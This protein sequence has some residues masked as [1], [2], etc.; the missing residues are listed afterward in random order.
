MLVLTSIT[1]I[2][3]VICSVCGHE[4]NAVIADN[5]EMQKNRKSVTVAAT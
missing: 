1:Q 4:Q 3:F 2:G 5:D